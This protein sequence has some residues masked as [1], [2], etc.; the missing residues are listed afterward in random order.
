MVGRDGILVTLRQDMR[1]AMAEKEAFYPVLEAVGRLCRGPDGARVVDT[2]ATEAPTWAVKY[3][4]RAA[5]VAGRHGA[6][7]RAA[8]H[9]LI[10]VE[11]RAL[12]DMAHPLAWSSSHRSIEVIDQA[13]RLSE[14]QRRTRTSAARPWSRSSCCRVG[15]GRRGPPGQYC[16][17]WASWSPSGLSSHSACA[18]RTC[19][20]R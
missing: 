6:R 17:R 7:E 14:T 8:E 4:R 3:L 20:G 9:G 2:L 13:L 18:A 16:L 11:V 15:T 1:D 12:V 10:D 5:E 19:D